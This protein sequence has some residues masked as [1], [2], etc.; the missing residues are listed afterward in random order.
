MAPDAPSGPGESPMPFI[1]SSPSAPSGRPTDT[2]AGAAPAELVR[3]HA[4]ET[5]SPPPAS[6][7]GT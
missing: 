2:S 6:D 7:E 3:A 4:L 5:E 1:Q